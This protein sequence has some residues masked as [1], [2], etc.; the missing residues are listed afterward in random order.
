MANKYKLVNPY[1]KGDF[2]SKIEA[3][4]SVEAAK[5]FYNSLSEHFNNSVPKFY[6]TIQKGGSTKGKF[7]HFQVKEKKTNDNVDYNIKPYEIKGEDSAMQ[8]YLKNFES[9]KGRYNGGA[10]KSSK[11][12][13]RKGSKKSSRRRSTRDSSDSES[14]SDDFYREARSYVPATSQPF[15]YM[16]YDPLVYKVDTVFFPTFYAYTSPF[17]LFN[18]KSG[19]YNVILS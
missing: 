11:K 15:Y 18:S 14:D 17:L 1:I 10:R 19:D 9:F 8:A 4:N 12:S 5:M 6:F 2:E 3:K 13:S 16:Y 7:Y